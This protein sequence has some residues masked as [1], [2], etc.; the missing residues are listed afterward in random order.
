MIVT[1]QQLDIFTLIRGHF[2]DHS[3]YFNHRVSLI[4]NILQPGVNVIIIYE[5]NLISTKSS[6]LCLSGTM[7]QTRVGVIVETVS[8]FPGDIW[9][10]LS[11]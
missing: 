11:G 7:F 1:K 6:Y 10:G 2:I 3:N 8:P 9:T 4:L 5:C